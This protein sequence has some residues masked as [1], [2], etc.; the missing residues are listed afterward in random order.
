[1]T[2]YVVGSVNGDLTLRVEELPAPGATILAE[3]PQRAGGGK[4]ANVAVAAARGGADVR[5]VAAVG[6]D[7][8]GEQSLAELRDEGVDT[9]GLAV[10]P[11]RATGLAVIY[12]DAKGE[13]VIVV[14]PGANSE[15][16]PER[17]NQGLTEI[18]ADDVCVVSYE[19][20][21]EAVNAAARIALDRGAALVVN[22]SPVRPLSPEVLDAAPLVVANAGEVERL[23]GA[24]GAARGAATLLERGC[25]SAVVTL[26]AEGAHVA[27]GPGEAEHV[28]AFTASVADTTGAGDTF[29]GLFA[30]AIASGSDPVHAARRGV[31]G[32]ALATERV[33]ARAAMPSS[34][35]IDALIERDS[36]GR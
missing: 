28:A 18:G 29:T 35:A 33:G 9:S 4:G 8:A 16:S 27:T 20:P 36:G 7:E 3:D 19:I 1:M 5:L 31:A 17:V 34:A 21:E 25:S 23:T 11:A 6:D 24:D 22:P 30:A 32:A 26:G 10:V 12:V 14:A 13:N 15:L 2:V